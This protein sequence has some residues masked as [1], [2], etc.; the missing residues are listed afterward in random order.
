MG[1]HREE[2]PVFP[3]S[4]PALRVQGRSEFRLAARS[5][6][7]ATTETART[8]AAT[9]GRTG[10]PADLAVRAGTTATATAAAAA[11]TATAAAAGV[12]VAEQEHEL[13]WP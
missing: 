7:D 1:I 11:A 13:A 10:A 6:A 8:T 9:R 2:R 12:G 4:G 3:G 5:P